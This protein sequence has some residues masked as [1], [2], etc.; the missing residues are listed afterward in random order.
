ME[1][2]D[3]SSNGG[4]RYIITFIDDFSL[5]DTGVFLAGDI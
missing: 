5:K 4:K 2:K 1:T 3:T